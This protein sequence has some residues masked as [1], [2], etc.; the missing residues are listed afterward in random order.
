M[1][2]PLHVIMGI[3]DLMPIAAN[4][5]RLTGRTTV[6]AFSLIAKALA[7][8]NEAIPVDDHAGTPAARER[9][10][11][12]VERLISSSQLQGIMIMRFGI[13]PVLVFGA[14]SAAAVHLLQARGEKHE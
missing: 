11:Q 9:L 6:Q 12:V 10:A 13:G 3:D 1:S 8:P 2:H 5:N 7:T 4:P 14:L